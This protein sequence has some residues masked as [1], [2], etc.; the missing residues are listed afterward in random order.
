MNQARLTAP[1]STSN[2]GPG[3]DT[4]G[5]ALGL[6]LEAVARI[7]GEGLSIEVEH[8]GP[9][10]W[11]PLLGGLVEAAAHGWE[12]ASGRVLPG[13]SHTISGKVPLARGLGSS[14]T[15]RL[16]G[17]AAANALADGP[18]SDEELLELVCRL[19]KHT[20]NAVPAMVGGL[21][22]SGW[23]GDKVRYFRSPVP[24]SLR[25][26]AL[27]PDRELATSEAR[28]VLPETVARED[29]VFNIQRAIWLVRA[30]AEGRVE[31]LGG[32]FADRLHQPYRVKL[33]PFLPAAI[34]AAEEAGAYGAFLSGA[35]STVLAITDR[36]RAETVARKMLSAL[37]S[38]NEKGET[39]ILEADNQGLTRK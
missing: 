35:G 27:V 21:T 33:L 12:E 19:E 29:A 16:L 1:V 17:V 13:V 34:E 23:D 39:M 9:D 4:L 3:F 25:F 18:L 6:R 11:G 10:K 30:M 37:N 31:D 38:K 26:V 20:D 8:H 15:Y 24:R 22:A 14:A 2:L 36:E 32:T 28:E 5:L 7:E